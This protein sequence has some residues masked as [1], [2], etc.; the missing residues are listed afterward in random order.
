MCCCNE[1][2]TLDDL[3]RSSF[4]IALEAQKS[5][6]KVPLPRNDPAVP[7]HDG[8]GARKKQGEGFLPVIPSQKAEAGRPP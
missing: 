3:Y 7:L 6:V 2:H 4:P 1:A 8:R 5:N